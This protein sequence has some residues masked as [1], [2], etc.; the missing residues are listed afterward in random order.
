MGGVLRPEIRRCPKST[1]RSIPRSAGDSDAEDIARYLGIE[2]ESPEATDTVVSAEKNRASPSERDIEKMLGI[3][4]S[5]EDEAEGSTCEA[6]WSAR[7]R[8]SQCS[9]GGGAAKPATTVAKSGGRNESA[10]GRRSRA[11]RPL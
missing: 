7:N 4:S 9:L 11:G 2:L 6:P 8:I 5:S 3:A 10:R 1:P